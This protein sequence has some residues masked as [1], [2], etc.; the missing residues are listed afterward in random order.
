MDLKKLVSTSAIVLIVGV[1]ISLVKQLFQFIHSL[2]VAINKHIMVDSL[3][4]A[5]MGRPNSQ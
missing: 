2:I 4:D 3:V 5:P 1:W